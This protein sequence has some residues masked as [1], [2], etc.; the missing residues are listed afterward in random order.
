M[1]VAVGS[2][3]PVKEAATARALGDRPADVLPVD[4][5]SGVSE[6]PRGRS[7]TITGAENRASAALAETDCTYGVGIEGGVADVDGAEGLWLI[8]WAAVTDGRGWGRGGG[9]TLRLPADIAERVRA[10]EELGPV[11]DDHLDAEGIAT[12]QG[13]AGVL[14][15]GSID[16]TSALAHGVSAAFGPFLAD[17]Y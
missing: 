17:V 12:D 15:D 11:M 7:E 16:R 6:Q 3:N 2:L 1:R 13:A 10:G 9:P 4:V 5:D 14:T 8:M